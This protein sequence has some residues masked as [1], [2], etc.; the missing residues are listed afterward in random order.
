MGLNQ[1][2]LSIHICMP[3]AL[4]IV[5]FRLAIR[6][7]RFK[8]QP[9]QTQARRHLF[10]AGDILCI[11]AIPFLIARWVL[12]HIVIAWGT[13]NIAGGST[14]FKPGEVE[15]RMSSSIYFLAFTLGKYNSVWSQKA[16]LL[17]FY[18][19]L[20]HHTSWGRLALRLAWFI[21][22]AT[23]AAVQVTTFTECRPFRNYYLILKKRDKCVRAVVQLFVLGILSIFTDLLLIIL[24]IPVLWK[25]T[26]PFWQKLQLTFLF[27][28]GIFVTL[29]T[30]IRV[31][32]NFKNS[33]K[34]MDRTMWVSIEILVS[35]FV[36][37]MPTI[38]GLLR[39]RHIQKSSHS[40]WT[41]HQMPTNPETEHSAAAAGTKLEQFDPFG[42]SQVATPD[43]EA[44]LNHENGYH[45]RTLVHP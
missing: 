42:A 45:P 36:A 16:V 8:H 34:Q 38:Y 13:T 35:A 41:G 26:Q 14:V 20:I 32:Q 18:H 1:T 27:S 24:P 22:F 21:L 15:R 33:T 23:Y 5:S 39:R 19:R 4:I 7:R 2:I 37:N 31:P 6:A 9:P 17:L 12:A 43:E 28:I 25:I 3:L 29:V 10:D 11:V 40:S 44:S 30:A